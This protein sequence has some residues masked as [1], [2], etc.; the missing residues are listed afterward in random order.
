MGIFGHSTSEEIPTRA[1]SQRVTTNVTSKTKKEQWIL[2]PLPLILMEL[3]QHL[4]RMGTM[5]PILANPVHKPRVVEM[6]A[7][8]KYKPGSVP[9]TTSLNTYTGKATNRFVAG[10]QLAGMI[11][12]GISN[13]KLLHLPTFS[14]IPPGYTLNNYSE[15][16]SLPERMLHESLL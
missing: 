10:Y 5:S 12:Q 7:Q 11:E 1:Q 13:S 16:P 8:G 15:R 3:F 6:I 14:P 2:T 4:Q 9:S